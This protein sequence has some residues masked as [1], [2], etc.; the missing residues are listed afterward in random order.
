[1]KKEVGNKVYIQD[2]DVTLCTNELNSCPAFIMTA[3][4]K[5]GD[6]VFISTK[7]TAF[8]FNTSFEGE[9][10][11]LIMEMDCFIDFDVYSKKPVR[12]IKKEM[13]ETQ[14]QAQKI[15]ADFNAASEEQRAKTYADVKDSILKLGHIVVSLNYMLQYRKKK[16]KFELPTA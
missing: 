6:G 13:V 11:E 9:E 14:E 4:T 12:T 8:G 16:L 7:N 2:Y 10:K 5:D 3:A 1:M 15:I